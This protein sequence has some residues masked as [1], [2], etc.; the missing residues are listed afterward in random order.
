MCVSLI[1]F[2]FP[3][4]FSSS[5]IF[6]PIGFESLAMAYVR[7]MFNIE[8]KNSDQKFGRHLI[9][10]RFQNSYGVMVPLLLLN[11]QLARCLDAT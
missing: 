6:K 3:L 4:F 10:N 7:H 8:E 9:R 1:S 2:S 11:R 5:R